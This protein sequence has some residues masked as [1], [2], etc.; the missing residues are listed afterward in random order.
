MNVVFTV[1]KSARLIQSL[2][3]VLTTLTADL[4]IGSPHPHR[5]QDRNSLNSSRSQRVCFHCVPGDV[6]QLVEHSPSMLEA[7]DSVPSTA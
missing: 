6:A 3:E 1:E 2:I 7:L 4:R 5:Q